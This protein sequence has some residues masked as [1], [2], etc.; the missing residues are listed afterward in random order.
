MLRRIGPKATIAAFSFLLGFAFSRCEAQSCGSVSFT[1]TIG[2]VTLPAGQTFPVTVDVPVTVSENA[3]SGGYCFVKGMIEF[4]NAGVS[5]VTVLVGPAAPTGWEVF[6]NAD[7]SG[8]SPTCGG[9]DMHA[10]FLNA[11]PGGL[12]ADAPTP[13]HL[14][15]IRVVVSSLATGGTIP[16]MWDCYC[17]PGVAHHEFL[18]YSG[19][20]CTSLCDWAV[21]ACDPDLV[22]TN[23]WI[24]RATGG[25]GGGGEFDKAAAPTWALVKEVYR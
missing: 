5:S 4:N 18:V 23:G 2:Q 6:E 16:L 17:G 3:T 24:K 14:A 13:K 11:G 1:G 7:P 10:W 22:L 12:N 8:V 20:G 15:T 25:G 9:N 19:T 21:N